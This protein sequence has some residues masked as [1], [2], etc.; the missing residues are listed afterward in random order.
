VLGAMAILVPR[1][2]RLKEW[3]YA[4]IFFYLK[5]AAASYAPVGGYGVYAFHILAPHFRAVLAVASWAIR[6]ESRI[7]AMLIPATKRRPV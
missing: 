1:F 6:P 4:G 7:I 5:G 2:P 3:A